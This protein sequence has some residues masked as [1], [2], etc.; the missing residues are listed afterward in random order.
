MLLAQQRAILVLFELFSRITF[1]IKKEFAGLTFEFLL[2]LFKI[3]FKWK[4]QLF[5]RAE[6]LRNEHTG[7]PSK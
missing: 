4:T 5:L 3:F 6:V 2:S 1:T 7:N